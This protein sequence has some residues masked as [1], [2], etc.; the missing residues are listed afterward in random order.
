MI[1]IKIFPLSMSYANQFK[2]VYRINM[3]YINMKS[4]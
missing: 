2:N 4:I 1:E 3:K